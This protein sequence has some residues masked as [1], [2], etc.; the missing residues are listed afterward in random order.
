MKIVTYL[1]GLKSKVGVGDLT[2]NNIFDVLREMEGK[3]CRPYTENRIGTVLFEVRHDKVFCRSLM[4]PT[5]ITSIPV[6]IDVAEGDLISAQSR[7]PLEY[8]NKGLASLSGDYGCDVS[9]IS[10]E[11][12]PF[13]SVSFKHEGE[14]IDIPCGDF[15]FT[16]KINN[17]EGFK[18][19]CLQGIGIYKEYGCGMLSITGTAPK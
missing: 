16:I 1:F 15:R 13:G 2:H 9:G 19:A 5:S 17:L 8:E 7:L 12:L 11:K 6:N 14:V 4:K 3:W 18:K 10:C